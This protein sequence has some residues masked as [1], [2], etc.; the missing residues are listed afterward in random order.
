MCSNTIELNQ[1][2]GLIMADKIKVETLINKERSKVWELF[3]KA[4]H[5]TKWNQAS[6]EWHCPNASNDLRPG[7]TFVYR[8]EAKDGS[9]GFDFGGEY[10]EVIENEKIVYELGD[11]RQ[12]EILFSDEGTSTKITETFDAEETNSMEMQKTGWQAIL[13]NFKN[14]AEA[15]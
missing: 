13:D 12:T 6:S 14:Y 11:G 15:Q 3:T 5:I 7:G 4:E 9:F 2:K 1:E 10:K 8:M